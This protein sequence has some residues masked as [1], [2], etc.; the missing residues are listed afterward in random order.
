MIGKT[1]TEEPM[2]T[3][4]SEQTNY[5]EKLRELIPAR[6]LGLYVF[7]I[8]LVSALAKTPAEVGPKFGWLLVV[9]TGVC[10]VVN[11][12]GRVIEKKG[13]ADAAISTGAFFLLTAT[14]RFTGPFAAFGD[15]QWLFVLASVAAG[16]FVVIV[17]LIW[18]P[19]KA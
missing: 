13:W 18:P 17:S 15:S 12:V 19:K 10:L 1:L 7:S 3:S 14:Q 4:A 2:G 6:T 16:A 8:G 5:V 11:F 9:I